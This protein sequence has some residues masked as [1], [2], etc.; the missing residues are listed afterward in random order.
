MKNVTRLAAVLF[1]LFAGL[2]STRATAIILF[3]S[4]VC[5][6][7]GTCG[8]NCATDSGFPSSCGNYGCCVGH[9]ANC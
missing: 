3:C 8:R 1:L 2:S 9:T 5:A 4:D 6:A 7:N